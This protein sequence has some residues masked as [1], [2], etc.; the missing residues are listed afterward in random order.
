MYAIRSYYE[1][2]IESNMRPV[3]IYGWPLAMDSHK[4][5]AHGI[6]DAQRQKVQTRKGR[7]TSY[8]VCYTKLL[9]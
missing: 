2:G 4:F 3:G 5:V 8:N 1:K 6:L 7:I 9:R